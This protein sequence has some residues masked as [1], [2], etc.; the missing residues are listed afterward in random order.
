M[1]LGEPTNVGCRGNS[2]N[3]ENCK[4]SRMIK[5]QGE[6]TPRKYYVYE[7]FRIEDNHVFYVGKGSNDRAWRIAPTHRNN[8]FNYYIKKY[9]CDY[10]IIHDGLEEKEA[11]ILENEL[12][13][14][15]K[16]QG[17][18]ECNIADTSSCNGGPS[19]K[20]SL[21]GMYGK[22]HTDETKAFLRALNSDGRNAAENNAQYKVSPKERMSPEV[23]ANWAEKQKKRK[24]GKTNPNA[25]HVILIN[26]LTREYQ[27]FDTTV[28]CASYILSNINSLATRYDT[29]EK[30]RYIIKHSHKTQAIYDKYAFIIYKKSDEIDIDN[31]VSSF[32]GRKIRK[33]PKYERPAK[34]DVTTTENVDGEKDAI[35]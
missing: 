33:I 11:Y 7:W 2:A 31:T 4:I 9:Q 27:I 3:G 23:Y 19:L 16:A 8:Y 15:Y 13:Q 6:P 10:R 32:C 29:K 26:I 14:K 21:N 17:Q 28:D 25:H 24:N 12:C 1:L 22:T 34:E 30:V 5:H 35:K 20:G 18:C